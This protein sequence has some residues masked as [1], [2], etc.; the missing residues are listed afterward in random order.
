MLDVF[1][2]TLISKKYVYTNDRAN[3]WCQGTR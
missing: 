3:D 1:N 2:T